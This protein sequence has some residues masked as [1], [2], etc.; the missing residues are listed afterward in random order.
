MYLQTLA[1]LV[2]KTDVLFN[3]ELLIR[4][5]HIKLKLVSFLVLGNIK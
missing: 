3:V 2:S 1:S 5:I 4:N